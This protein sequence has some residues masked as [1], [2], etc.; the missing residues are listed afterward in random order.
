MF[1]VTLASVSVEV[2]A[3][4]KIE[5]WLFI[6]ICPLGRRF[7]TDSSELDDF[8][9]SKDLSLSSSLIENTE[10]VSMNSP[11]KSEP[12]HSDILDFQRNVFV[13]N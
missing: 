12:L 9:W 1:C 7:R 8:K 13:W 2:D 4:E 11:I 6:D 5:S 3:C 10:I